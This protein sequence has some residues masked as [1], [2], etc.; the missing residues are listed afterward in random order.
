MVE[1]LTGTTVAPAAEIDGKIGDTLAKVPN[2]AFEEWYTKDH[3]V[4][5]IILS[6]LSS[7]SEKVMTQVDA[8]ETTT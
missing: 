3:Q 8:K 7:L 5:S 1:H 4:L 2:P 6:S